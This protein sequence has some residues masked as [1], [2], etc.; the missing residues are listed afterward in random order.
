MRKLAGGLVFLAGVAA[1]FGL[2]FYS[3]DVTGMTRGGRP[4]FRLGIQTTSASLSAEGAFRENY[5]R[6]LSGY[7]GKTDAKALKYAGM[8]GLVGALGDP[9]TNFFPPRSRRPSTR[10]RGRTSSAWARA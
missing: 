1:C 8:E 7:E 4:D 6:I 5:A 2:G 3:R 10:R 9:H